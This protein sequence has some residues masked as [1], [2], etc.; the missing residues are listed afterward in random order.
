MPIKISNTDTQFWPT[1]FG[2]IKQSSKTTQAS[3][4][5]VAPNEHIRMLVPEPLPTKA[6]TLKSLF[7]PNNSLCLVKMMQNTIM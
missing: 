6:Q 5:S 3:T 7:P 4:T 1:Y 2:L